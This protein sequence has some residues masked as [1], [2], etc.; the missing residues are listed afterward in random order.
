MKFNFSK[1]SNTK[2]VAKNDIKLILLNLF[3]LI[4][5]FR[6]LKIK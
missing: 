6:M 2:G 1:D 4:Q 5:E 3:F